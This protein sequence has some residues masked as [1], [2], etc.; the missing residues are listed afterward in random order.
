MKKSEAKGGQSIFF[1]ILA[2][3]VW[4]IFYREDLLP[5]LPLIHTDIRRFILFNR[6]EQDEGDEFNTVFLSCLS[7]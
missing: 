7:P 6:D 3:M 5:F 4:L 2:V 1:M